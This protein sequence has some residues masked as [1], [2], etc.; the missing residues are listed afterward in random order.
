[1]D[2]KGGDEAKKEEEVIEHI[3]CG[4]GKLERGFFLVSSLVSC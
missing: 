1:M 3:T 2:L 4:H